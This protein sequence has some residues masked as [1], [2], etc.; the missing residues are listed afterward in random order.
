MARRVTISKHARQLLDEFANDVS[1][2]REW[3]NRYNLKRSRA[4]LVRYL[5]RLEQAA[6]EL[7]RI[8]RKP[9]V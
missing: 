7:A 6:C 1:D 5:A 9:R 8:K 4:N 3:N 2:N